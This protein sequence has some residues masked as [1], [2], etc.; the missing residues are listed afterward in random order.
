MKK[1]KERAELVSEGK[2]DSQ[3][4][5][6]DIINKGK[7]NSQREDKLDLTTIYQDLAEEIKGQV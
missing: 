7:G 2:K 5:I 4:A 3:N 1:E 6:F